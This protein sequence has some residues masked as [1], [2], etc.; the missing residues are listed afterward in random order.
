QLIIDGNTKE[1]NTYTHADSADL[2]FI[3]ST[4]RV[5]SAEISNMY[6]WRINSRNNRVIDYLRVMNSRLTLSGSGT[7]KF[8]QA[9]EIYI[10]NSTLKL[11]TDFE[12]GAWTSEI[13]ISNSRIQGNFKLDLY[14]HPSGSHF[15][16]S[17]NYFDKT[18]LDV[19]GGGLYLELNNNMFDTYDTY[20][21]RGTT[22]AGPTWYIFGRGNT[23]IGAASGDTP[24]Q[25]STNWTTKSLLHDN[26]YDTTDLTN[27][28]IDSDNNNYKM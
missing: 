21:V 9:E 20:A 14:S 5:L 23:F 26:V 28:S 10:S 3:D 1:A 13:L 27:E 22:A 2:L 18:A 11:L 16:F 12:I 15:K 7:T 17:N 6:D 4:S 25:K 8:P 24:F 19:R